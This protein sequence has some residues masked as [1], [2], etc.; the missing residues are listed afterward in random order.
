MLKIRLQRKGTRNRPVYRLVVAESTSRRDGR[1]N[2]VLGH[3]APVA[4]GADPEYAIRLDRVDYWQSVGAQPTDTART[5][6]NR[7]RREAPPAEAT[8][9][10]DTDSPEAAAA[11]PAGAAAE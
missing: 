11:A 7:A 9:S 2:E 8:A 4:R 5:L 10:A 1:H 6:I 3:Y